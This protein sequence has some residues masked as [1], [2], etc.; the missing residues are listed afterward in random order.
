MF[1]LNVVTR[2]RA[3]YA[4]MAVLFTPI[5]IVLVEH[6]DGSKQIVDSNMLLR[7]D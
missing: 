7:A 4:C 3:F 6:N 5:V 1:Y 2:I